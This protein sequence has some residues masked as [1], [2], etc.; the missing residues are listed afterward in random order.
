MS[1]STRN[2]QLDDFSQLQADLQASYQGRKAAK[3]HAARSNEEELLRY[4]ANV[5]PKWSSKKKKK[6]KRPE[7]VKI[8]LERQQ[9][10]RVMA[11][12]EQAKQMQQAQQKKAE[13]KPRIGEQPPKQAK[14]HLL[15]EIPAAIPPKQAAA[16]IRKSWRELQME[17]PDMRYVLVNNSVLAHDKSCS[18]V[19]AIPDDQLFMVK[20][21][22]TERWFCD[23]CY[24]RALI[25]NGLAE[26]QAGRLDLY[27]EAFQSLRME[28]GP[29]RKLI[30]GY[31]AKLYDAE[32]DRIFLQAGEE[33]W[34]L[35]AQGQQCQLYEIVSREDK[36]TGRVYTKLRQ[37]LLDDFE[38]VILRIGQYPLEL[39]RQQ[40]M[41]VQRRVL[42]TRNLRRLR[43]ISVLYRY[44]IYADCLRQHRALGWKWGFPMKILDLQEYPDSCFS[45][46]IC[47]IRR[48]DEWLFMKAMKDMKYKSLTI[49][50]NAYADFCNANLPANDKQRLL[51]VLKCRWR[52]NKG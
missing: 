46:I 34:L 39:Q 20:D 12:R 41:K 48:R 6:K 26:G 5:Q 14:S 21:F 11:R 31:G 3:D 45:I 16:P 42:G 40:S 15:F 4:L 23:R 17:N 33:R 8:R 7:S 25:R 29:L 9:Q 43:C 2:H 32:P 51:A 19:T 50:G 52:K 44:Y 1:R 24:Y 35:V 27:F 49:D 47:R 10:D 28:G 36:H 38:K 22:P 13:E 37:D 18:E 30:L